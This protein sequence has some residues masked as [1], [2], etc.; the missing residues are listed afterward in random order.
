MSVYWYG[1]FYVLAFFAGYAFLSFLGKKRYFRKFPVLQKTLTADLDYLMIFLLLGVLLGGRL[2][3]FLIY[4]L[5]NLGVE[6]FFSVWNG[7]MSF[8]GGIVGVVVSAIVF[9]FL[10]RL[11]WKEWL[12]LFDCILVIVPLGI[13][14][15]RL[16]NFLNQ[17]LYGIVFQNPGFSE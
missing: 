7:G 14:L 11:S 8:I 15:G 4:D 6:N 1:I 13:L 5:S 17:E 12:I 3:H 10:Y 2:G 16:G 9:R